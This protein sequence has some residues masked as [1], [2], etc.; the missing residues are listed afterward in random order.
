MDA[1]DKLVAKHFPQVGP[2]QVLM[3]MVEGEL[4]QFA[5]RTSLREAKKKTKSPSSRTYTIHEIPLIPVSEL[6]WANNEDGVEG[7]T[8][9]SV[10]ESWL[11]GVEGDNIQKKLE[12]VVL[13]MET[14]FGDMP[15]SDNAKEYIQQ[16]MSYLVFLKTLTMAI[17]NFNASAAG[18]NFEA[19]LSA[20][21]GGTQIP[22][23]GADTIADIYVPISSEGGSEIVPIS[24]KLY[25]EKGLEVGGSFTDLANDLMVPSNKWA[26]WASK[27]VHGGGAMRYI[28]CT[29]DF[30]E[31]VQGDPLSRQG[32]IKFYEFDI[33][34][35]NLFDLFSRAGDLS[36]KAIA[37]EEG[38]KERLTAWD[39]AGR[40]DEIPDVRTQDELGNMT[41]LPEPSEK[42]DPNELADVFER[43]FLMPLAPALKK[44][45]FRSAQVTA[46]IKGIRVVYER[47]MEETGEVNKFPAA[48]I[49]VEMRKVVSN[50]EVKEMTGLTLV[51]FRDGVF[52]T[53]EH[54]GRPAAF[55]AFKEQ[56]VSVVDLRGQ[57]IE[58]LSW[59]YADKKA[60]SNSDIVQ[61]YNSL[62]QEAKKVAIANTR[63][64]LTRKKWLIPRGK[65]IAYAAE[66]GK[67]P[68]AVLP[69][70]AKFVQ[71]MLEGVRNDVMDDVFRIF[72]QMAQMSRQL[73]L[74]FA[75][76]LKQPEEAKAGAKAGE[77]AA[78]GAREFA[79]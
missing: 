58:A 74:F 39:A 62:S 24:L 1:F 2:L 48:A 55:R 54:E 28:A 4:E 57:A 38:F 72:D 30:E 18:F 77:T 25:E 59:A 8:Q 40:K 44:A 49:K 33:T 5:P 76:G 71:D 6:G 27:E 50:Q 20:L 63:G 46:L 13:R 19:F 37:I 9:R 68:F 42:G 11:K 45:G 41:P 17:T 29:K 60:G 64:Y 66:Q 67:A 21:L 43:D 10:L 61:W 36:R 3:E 14:G 7:E 15:K 56:V 47:S 53:G 79:K 35:N 16:V 69:I 12:N 34:R 78:K 70:G 65:A 73:N 22:A 23:S 31:V 52:G 26:A 75:K 32:D 51:Q